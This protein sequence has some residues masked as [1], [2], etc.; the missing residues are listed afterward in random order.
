M[1]TFAV[2][3][4]FQGECKNPPGQAT[5]TD[6]ALFDTRVNSTEN[7]DTN[8]L[9]NSNKNKYNVVS[10]SL[11]DGVLTETEVFGEVYP[12]FGVIVLS[13]AA[14]DAFCEK[15]G[16]PEWF[17]TMAYL[18]DKFVTCMTLPFKNL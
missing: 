7:S 16:R 4:Y 1:T 18:A 13:A 9:G 3:N 2:C 14:L 10:G 15:K 6:L 17:V 5:V 11:T 12:Q 8:Q